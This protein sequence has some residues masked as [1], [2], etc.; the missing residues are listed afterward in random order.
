MSAVIPR[1]PGVYF[2]P[3][4]PPA[5]PLLPPLDVAAFVG[6]AERGPLDLPVPVED[7]GAYAAIFG[8]DLAVAQDPEQAGET[9]YANLPRSVDGFFANGGRRCYVVRIAGRQAQ[10]ARLAI[11]GVVA[12]ESLGEARLAWSAASSPG[13][14]A[15]DVQLAA[16]LTVTP[17]PVSGLASPAA[18]SFQLLGPD[19]LSWQPG[20]TSADV[21]V[22]DV[23][24]LTFVDG[25][26][27]LFPISSIQQDSAIDSSRSLVANRVWEVVTAAP[28]SPAATVLNAWH[29][30]TTGKRAL[31]IA[32]PALAPD[33]GVTVLPS[34]D[35]SS[36]P[37]PGDLLVLDLSDGGSYLL[38][39]AS[40]D[41]VQFAA[42]PPQLAL[43]VTPA[44][45]M[46]LDPEGSPAG[47]LQAV[48]LLRFDLIVRDTGAQT[49]TVW[50]L[51][52]NVGHRRFWGD[53]AFAE[54]SALQRRP[55]SGST[56]SSR[57][58]P[59]GPTI[60][61]T[62]ASQAARLFRG[63]QA[64]IR[65]DPARDGSLDPTAFAAVLAPVD[66]LTP[67]FLPIG[68][69]LVVDDASF[70]GPAP[71][72]LG[73]DD[74]ASY[75]DDSAALFLDD[76]LVPFPANPARSPAGLLNAALDRYYVQNRRLRGIHS[77]TFV[78]EVVQVS[79]PDAVHRSWSPTV[80]AAA[81][82]LAPTAT[83]TPAPTCP[84]SG[85]FVDC[86]LP[87]S[88]V[89]I[90]PA[91][92]DIAGGLEVTLTGDDFDLAGPVAVTFGTHLATNVH[93][94]SRTS[95]TA[96]VPEGDG[97]ASVDVQVTNG[98][99]STTL[100]NGFRYVDQPTTPPLPVLARLSDYD[101]ATA[102]L[103]PI[104]RSLLALC[105]ART[106]AVAILILPRHFEKPQCLDWLRTL[107]QR[108]G[109]PRSG[110]VATDLGDVADLSYAAVYHPWLL[111][112]D[113]TAPDGTRLTACD[114]V[115][116]G[117]IAAREQQR[118]VW[119]APA[120]VPGQRILDLTPAISND[121]WAD[122]FA[123]QFNLIRPEPRDFR[124]MSA[125]TLADE[126]SLL[127]LSVRRL[128][129]LLRKV[130]YE[131]GMDY[132]FQSNTPPFR[133]GVRMAMEDVLR[134]MF[135]RGAFAG[136][137]P[138]TSYRVV[139]DA[140][141]NP[142]A[143]VDQGQFVA[144]VQVAPSQPMEFITVVLTRVGEGILQVTEV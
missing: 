88:L 7:S 73:D 38:R 99:G 105:Q 25:Q 34:D 1:L 138:A 79:V 12:I 42:S 45:V 89:A 120:N 128:M 67:T 24:Q 51:G 71:A 91:Y 50:N 144:L 13:R 131:R 66:D 48:D 19:L 139:V 87:P 11:P 26:S 63:L 72:D 126:R 28:D 124:A 14:W 21:Q 81:P 103:V 36:L 37:R 8:G 93:V 27:W 49:T 136:P 3:P 82:V 109:L 64:G 86:R 98:N 40:V 5:A 74:L 35:D 129:I 108:L 78:E 70:L 6:F 118:Q 65:L 80:A 104:Q 112:A 141:V 127:Q 111:L 134:F 100:A 143:S 113:P 114:G 53:V 68:I 29:L 75:D 16:R 39:V 44:T 92:G 106:D 96:T 57:S 18:P 61:E 22:G 41:T 30:T 55:S 130:A 102:P 137:T 84:P 54:S 90:A 119:V 140:S 58:D 60:D 97:A 69:P 56:T 121:D 77:L 132:V 110:G 101:L 85:P 115:I 133:E 94:I 59:V 33:F 122:L 107:R 32:D 2:L 15:N 142:P 123:L 9:V 76:Y 125:H 62:P 95:I 20:T 4:P 17:L 43:R 83:A 10:T 52:F 135:D 117:M 47:S 31:A 46:R 116:C 23:L